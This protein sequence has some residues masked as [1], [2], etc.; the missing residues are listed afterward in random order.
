MERRGALS[1]K[2]IFSSPIRNGV[3][4]VIAVRVVA[5]LEIRRM[6]VFVED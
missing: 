1:F 3:G 5:A 4:G 6:V 2:R